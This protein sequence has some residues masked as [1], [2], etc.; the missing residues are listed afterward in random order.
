M[1]FPRP[2][3]GGE[4]LRL[5]GTYHGETPS[6]R[7][8][9]ATRGAR[10]RGDNRGR[11]VAHHRLLSLGRGEGFGGFPRA[12]GCFPRA[13]LR[14]PPRAHPPPREA[15]PPASCAASGGGGPRRRRGAGG[16]A[17]EDWPAPW[18]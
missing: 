7:G 4:L 16:G 1:G 17:R 3:G 2:E 13:S 8:R 14:R 5:L 9:G 6:V 18:R 15:P 12:P 10:A 11:A